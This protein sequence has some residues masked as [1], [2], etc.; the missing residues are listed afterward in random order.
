[1]MIILKIMILSMKIPRDS[2]KLRLLDVVGIM[3]D[4]NQQQF[5]KIVGFGSLLNL[6]LNF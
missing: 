5:G 3:N 2:E 4:W 6:V 1:M